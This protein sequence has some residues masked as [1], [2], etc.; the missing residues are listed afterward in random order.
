MPLEK[1]AMPF[2][3][4]WIVPQPATELGLL[5]ALLARVKL[6]VIH[7]EL[8][9]IAAKPALKFILTYFPVA[10]KRQGVTRLG[11]KG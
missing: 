7:E 5:S 1:A 6:G 2:E 9:Y 8:G 3:A 11:N 10:A 4:Y